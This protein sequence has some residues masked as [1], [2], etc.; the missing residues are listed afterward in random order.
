M[1]AADSWNV[2]AAG[3][4]GLAPVLGVR[5]DGTSH[6][7]SARGVLTT[8]LGELVLPHGGRAWTGTLIEALG[9]LDVQP[10]AARRVVATLHERGWLERQQVGRR[11]R[12][13]L[14]SWARD[15]L[16]RGGERIYGFGRQEPAWDGAWRLLL[17][18]VPETHRHLR[19][20]LGVGLSWAGYGPLGPGLWASA[21]ADAEAD[22][23]ALLTE[24]GLDHATTFT[25]A[26]GAL[27]DDRQLAARAWDLGDVA[28]RYRAFLAD[29]AEGPPADPSTA[30]A[31]LVDLVHRWRR[32][33]LLDPG[34][35]AALL[36]DGWPA[37]AAASRFA[38]LRTALSD[39]A[40][41]WWHAA[42]RRHG[43]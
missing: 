14:T 3:A 35:P 36:P 19:Y 37:P 8:V 40:E 21:H 12:W 11:A 2:T 33:P 9:L 5:R 13:S 29:E 39:P 17:V 16:E 27:G 28:D 41:R 31:R 38:D 23:A 34:L 1:S 15:L 25:A 4:A 6:A 42:E 20:R 10:K 24:L 22:V 7:D 32:F 30:V 43:G 26:V 18:T